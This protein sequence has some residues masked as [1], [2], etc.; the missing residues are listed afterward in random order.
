VTAFVAGW[1]S[2]GSGSIA[3]RYLRGDANFDGITDIA[4]WAILNRENPAL[5][6][7]ALARLTNVP[8]PTAL[9]LFTIALPQ[10]IMM[11]R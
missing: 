2:Q 8:E 3:A 10:A 4:D 11:R 5:G 7:A 6:L 1:L 9:L